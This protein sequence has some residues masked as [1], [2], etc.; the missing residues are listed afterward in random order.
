MSTIVLTSK[1]IQDAYLDT[2]DLDSS[3]FRTKFKRR[4]PFSQAPRY[5]KTLTEKDNT[6]VFPSIANLIDG[7]WFEG[8]HIA[9]KMFYGSTIDFYIG[10]VKIDSHPYEFLAD[11]WGNYMADT[12]TRSQELNNK[13]TQTTEN[14]VPLHF[15][16]CNTNAFLPLCALSM[17]ECKIVVHWDATHLATL[18]SAEKEAKFYV[19]AIWLDTAERASLVSRPMDFMITQ[20]Q[21]LVHSME[22]RVVTRNEQNVI[23][24]ITSSIESIQ[25]SQFQHPV[26]SLFFGYESL[27]EDDVNDRFTFAESD[28]LIN[29]T[30]LFE[31]MTPMYHH[32]VQNYMHSRHGIISFDDVNK[33]PFYTRFYAFHFCRD[34]SD[35][36]SPGACNFSMLGESKLILRDIEIGDERTNMAENDIRVFAVS[37][38]VLRIS[39]GLGGIL[40]S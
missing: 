22:N 27:Q 21:N 37:W 24:D 20:V 19:N 36:T 28:L 8:D 17:H 38:Q 12:Y 29:G 31:K 5:V 40:F 4:T 26:R 30:P 15:F 32:V 3:M 13:T 25:L 10:G 34:A 16:W 35:Y 6:I 2:N 9:T 7:A 1:G 18:T 23:T 39:N 14:F 33:C 11:I